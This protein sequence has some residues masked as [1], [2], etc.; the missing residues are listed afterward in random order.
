MPA[1]EFMKVFHKNIAQV[2]AIEDGF[3]FDI[4]LIR[5]YG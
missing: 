2:L 4:A 1:I 5:H 3:T